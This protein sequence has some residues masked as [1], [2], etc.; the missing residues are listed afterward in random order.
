M[1]ICVPFNKTKKRV[2]A[3]LGGRINRRHRDLESTDPSGI[4]ENKHVLIP[5]H[6]NWSD[7]IDFGEAIQN[8]AQ[9]LAEIDRLVRLCDG[10]YG[11]RKLNH[12]SRRVEFDTQGACIYA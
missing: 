1:V 8:G 10:R 6:R 3:V 12:L 4:S 5:R 2:V 11:C 7:W 9:V